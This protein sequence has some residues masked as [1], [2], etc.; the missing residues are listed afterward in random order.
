MDYLKIKLNGSDNK[1]HTLK[2]F[3]TKMILYFYPK[4]NTPGCSMEAQEYSSYKDD[5]EKVGY[6]IIGV[7]RDSIKSHLKFIDKMKINF[8]LLSDENEELCKAFNVLKEK[9]MF[10]KKSIGVE[11]STFIL[12]ENGE[13]VHEFR[14]VKAAG[15]A[16]RM[17][18]LVNEE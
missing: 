16:K 15:D 17:L 1:E 13:I 2:E 6:K 14:K 11:R 4:D 10:G 3:K 12:N 18:D 5:F 8:L 7:S 9:N